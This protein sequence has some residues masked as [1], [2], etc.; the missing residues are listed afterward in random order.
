MVHFKGIFLQ[1]GT[2]RN[3][4]TVGKDSR[5]LGWALSPGSPEYDAVLLEHEVIRE[6]SD[7][8]QFR[9]PETWKRKNKSERAYFSVYF[10]PYMLFEISKPLPTFLTNNSSIKIKIIMEHWWNY[11]DKINCHTWRKT[12][13]IATSST[14]GS[15]VVKVLRYKSESPGV[16]G[17]FFSWHLR[18]PYA[19]G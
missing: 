11:I 5:S 10:S 7:W 4:E 9:Q 3:I 12:F 6:G 15:V 18:V 14:W 17:F 19:L 13:P 16:A 1:D 8:Y 2:R